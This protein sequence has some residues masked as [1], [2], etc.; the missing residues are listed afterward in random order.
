MKTIRRAFIALLAAV[1]V[2]IL[3]ITTPAVAATPVTGLVATQTASDP[4]PVVLEDA[5]THA[6]T[7]TDVTF[8][9]PWA[10]FVTGSLIPLVVAFLARSNWSETWKGR[11][12]FILSVATATFTVFIDTGG[13]VPILQLLSA[14]FATL[15]TSQ[16]TY[17]TVWKGSTIQRGLLAIGGGDRTQ[18]S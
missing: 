17:R 9:V 16:I 8:S 2:V 15:A 14:V 1:I 12:S 4:G 13:S 7:T 5:G 11:A 18:E 3:S 6:D 10:V